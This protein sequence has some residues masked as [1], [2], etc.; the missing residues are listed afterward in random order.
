MQIFKNIK[1]KK[2]T[3]KLIVISTISSVSTLFVFM[4]LV[5]LNRN[6]ILDKIFELRNQQI[7]DIVNNQIANDSVL[8]EAG[9]LL[10]NN[11]IIALE[12]EE[13]LKQE[14]LEKSKQI[15]PKS[16]VDIVRTANPAVVAI[17]LY[18]DQ[19]KYKNV[20]NKET[21][22]IEQVE[23]GTERKKVGSG[24]GFLISSDG[25]IVTNR[26]V[27]DTKDVN[28]EVTFNNGDI[29]KSEV[30]AIDPIY[31]VAIMKISFVSNKKYPYLELGD[32]DVLNVG[33]SVI[34]IGNALGELKNSVSVG[35]VSGLSR[36]VTANGNSGLV[37]KLEKVIQTDAA[38]NKGN[39]GGPLIDLYGKVVGVNVA[40]ADKSQSIG[41]A[42]P[43]NSIKDV[44]SS[45]KKTGKI[46]RP[47]VG[48]RYAVITEELKLSKDLPVDSGILIVAG[49][50]KEDW[51]IS[52]GSPAETAGL[53][54][55]DIITEIAGKKITKDEDFAL[56]I[57]NKKVGDMISIKFLRNNVE[58]TVFLILGQAK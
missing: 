17:T 19:P 20:L 38:I 48:V 34:A 2:S 35:I 11:S 18:K 24:S 36:S 4:G 26:H 46:V 10:E 29:Q 31:D 53:K 50:G 22:K 28:Y 41:F 1:I 21:K 27:V 52:P 6:F 9:K 16:I 15:S 58:Q 44:I 40:I 56:I 5:L 32:S 8:I 42:L 47:F 54:E 3:R 51:A 13:K 7:S 43:I 23:D 12:N 55:G 14:E 57:R 49:S 33:E 39:S 45:V 30:L 25:L 37:E